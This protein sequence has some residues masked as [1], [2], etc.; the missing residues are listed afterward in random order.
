MTTTLASFLQGLEATL[1][2]APPPTI[3]ELLAIVGFARQQE[4]MALHPAPAQAP[5][6][7][8][9]QYRDLEALAQSLLRL[10]RRRAVTRVDIPTSLANQAT[11]FYYSAFQDWELMARLLHQLD[12]A[13]LTALEDALQQ[14]DLSATRGRARSRSPTRLDALRYDVY[15]AS[16]PTEWKDADIAGWPCPSAGTQYYSCQELRDAG[17]RSVAA[18]DGR[19]PEI[20]SSVLYHPQW[21][22][23]LRELRQVSD[24][25]FPTDTELRFH[26]KSGRHRSVAAVTLVATVLRHNGYLVAVAHHGLAYSKIKHDRTSCQTCSQKIS[27]EAKTA[28]IRMW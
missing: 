4:N 23:L 22:D 20:L 5:A 1:R 17:T 7:R 12:E 19:H 14:A 13:D 11:G 8:S 28:L 25:G 3:P 9:T 21:L 6:P 15:L 24:R 10:W 16:I 18:H 26:C 27:P 2:S